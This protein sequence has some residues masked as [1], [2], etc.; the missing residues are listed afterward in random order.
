MEE[1]EALVFVTLKRLLLKKAFQA[2]MAMFLNDPSV[3]LRLDDA[4]VLFRAYRR[5]SHSPLFHQDDM[6]TLEKLMD[7][8]P[9]LQQRVMTGT[10]RDVAG[11]VTGAIANSWASQ[12]TS[13]TES[14]L[15][16]VAVPMWNV[17][18]DVSMFFAEGGEWENT[19]FKLVSQRHLFPI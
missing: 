11:G 18:S 1:D 13:E 6:A 15:P 5:A 10:G 3:R 9:Q 12:L 17:E 19:S 16:P 7:V 14:K 8:L 4:P 2:E